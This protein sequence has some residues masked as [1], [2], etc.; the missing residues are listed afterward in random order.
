MHSVEKYT[1]CLK[2]AYM[3]ISFS[4]AYFSGLQ[5][6]IES[7]PVCIEIFAYQFLTYQDFL[8]HTCND[9]CVTLT[10]ITDVHL[11]NRAVSP[12]KIFINTVSAISSAL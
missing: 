4:Y 1:N 11:C 6:M 7:A 10:V 9:I 2:Y 8:L 3:T 5:R 12:L